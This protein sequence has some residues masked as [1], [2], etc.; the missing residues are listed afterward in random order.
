LERQRERVSPSEYASEVMGEWSDAVG[1]LFSRELLDR[2]T[3]DVDIPLMRDLK[4]P[5]RGVIGVDWGISYDR[6]AAVALYRLPVQ[7]LNPDARPMPRF[8]AF[9]YVWPQATPLHEVVE[10]IAVN[11][12]PFAYIA[13]ECNGVGAMPASE[14]RR[15]GAQLRSH[16]DDARKKTWFFVATTAA[17]KTAAYGL[18]LGLL[19]REALVLPRHPDLL[20]QLAGL[21][22]SQGERGFLSIEAES[23]A[24]HDDVAD[25]LMLCAC[26]YKPPAAHRVVCHLGHLAGSSRAPADARVPELSC[27]VVETGGGLRVP[28]VPTLQS[29]GAQ[30]FSTYAPVAPAQPEGFRAGQFFVKTTYQGVTSGDM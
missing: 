24:V 9:P 1:S 17:G 12:S 15:R 5:A 2:Q 7:S 10:C 16:R 11:L 8:V 14:I 23:A 22:F 30:D 4:T 6:S 3:C 19:E 18:V 26:P 25:A 21:Q 20:R 29:V 13:P 27:D 28:Q